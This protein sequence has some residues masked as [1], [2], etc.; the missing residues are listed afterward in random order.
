MS[1]VPV[2]GS[3]PPGPK[4][5]NPI[6]GIEPLASGPAIAPTGVYVPVA[7]SKFKS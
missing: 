3:T 2:L 7:G 6:P 4:L 1:D 5:S